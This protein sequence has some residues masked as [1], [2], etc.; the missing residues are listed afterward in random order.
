MRTAPGTAARDR[1]ILLDTGCALQ[2]AR[3]LRKWGVHYNQG[4]HMLNTVDVR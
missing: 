3:E 2:M 4:I 1:P